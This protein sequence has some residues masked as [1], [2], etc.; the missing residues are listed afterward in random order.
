MLSVGTAYDMQ[1]DPFWLEEW[2]VTGLLKDE[3][4]WI[5]F[6]NKTIEQA[7]LFTFNPK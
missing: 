5:S 3:V 1:L 6:K 7:M 2:G 4:P